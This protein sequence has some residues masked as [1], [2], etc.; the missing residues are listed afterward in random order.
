MRSITAGVLCWT[1][2]FPALAAEPVSLDWLSGHWCG[3]QGQT[4]IEEQ[5]TQPAGGALLGLSRTLKDDRMTGFE[6][7]RIERQQ[8][9]QHL[10]AQPGGS[11]PTA[12]RLIES[13]Q[14]SAR[15][16]NPQHDFPQTIR[17][18]REGESLRAEISGPDGRGG[19]TRIGFE[20]ARCPG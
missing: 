2:A 19:E 16:S 3:E 11:P 7:M 14:Q 4:R 5:W 18:W 20:Y 13:G 10:L 6:F 1:L 8:G 17:Y 15:F 9:V 12:F